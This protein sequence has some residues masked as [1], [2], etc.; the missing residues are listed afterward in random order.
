M[1]DELVEIAA[2]VRDQADLDAVLPQCRESRKRV[3]VERE[4]LVLLPGAHE[5]RGAR[6][7]SLAFAAHAEHD[8]LGERD[9]DLVVVGV[10]GMALQRVERVEPGLLVACRVEHEPVPLADL[11][12]SLGAELGA[13]PGKREVDVEDD[14][15]EHSAEDSLG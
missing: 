3:L 9:P 8:L 11:A 15:L 12:V 6:A 14:C 13:G 5:L 2:A 1:G 4:A 10:I 7:R